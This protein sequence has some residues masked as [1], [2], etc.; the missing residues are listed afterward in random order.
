MEHSQSIRVWSGERA[1]LPADES[2][3]SYQLRCLVG[4]G[5]LRV[6]S[7]ADRQLVKPGDQLTIFGDDIATLTGK[8]N[9][10]V[11]IKNFKK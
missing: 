10:L 9:M 11:E 8:E 3:N 2:V 6:M 1:L 5:Y 7:S 4:E